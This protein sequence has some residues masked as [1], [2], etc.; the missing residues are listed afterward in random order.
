MGTRQNDSGI[1]ITGF[2]KKTD[3]TRRPSD[4]FAAQAFFVGIT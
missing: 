2:G 4:L 1:H 3:G